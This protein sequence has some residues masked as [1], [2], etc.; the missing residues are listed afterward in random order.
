VL[1]GVCFY[2]YCHELRVETI[3]ARYR[4]TAIKL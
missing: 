2:L 4:H 3:R 1:R